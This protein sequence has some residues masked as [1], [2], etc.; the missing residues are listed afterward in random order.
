MLR[1]DD[2]G[3]HARG[4][5]VLVA[6]GDLS[7]AIGTQVIQSAVMANFGQTLGKAARQVMRHGH[8]RRGLVRSVTE[9]HALVTCTDQV[10]RVG[11]DTGLGLVGFVHALSDI[12]ALL[13][14]EAHDAA[15]IAVKAVLGAVIADAANG[16]A[17]DLLYVNISLRAN[18]AGDDHGSGSHECLACATDV[19]N[20]GGY[21][22]G[23]HVA[24]GL[25]RGLLGKNGI[26]NGVGHLVC[27]LVGMSL[28]HRF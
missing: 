6:D 25:Q 28:G 8:Q 26:E 17:C 3:V 5:A 2:D 18:L 13:V 27:D 11:G 4:L 22:V 15:R 14:D 16:V 9:H 24:L 1:G 20:V 19:V 7:F 23:R 12:G 10:D 21:A